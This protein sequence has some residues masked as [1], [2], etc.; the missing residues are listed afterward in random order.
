MWS[1]NSFGVNGSFPNGF[2]QED[3]LF[4]TASFQNTSGPLEP[5]YTRSQHDVLVGLGTLN[6]QNDP[7]FHKNNFQ[8]EVEMYNQS[9]FDMSPQNANQTAQVC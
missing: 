2:S 9:T 5:N 1:N 3:F 4:P 8:P 7:T 6:G